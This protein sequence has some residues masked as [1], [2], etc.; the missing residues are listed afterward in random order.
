MVRKVYPDSNPDNPTTGEATSDGR[1]EESPMPREDGYDF[2][3]CVEEM[4][5]QNG[6][7]IVEFCLPPMYGHHHHYPYPPY[8]PYG[9]GGGHCPPPP[10]PEPIK[11][12]GRIKLN[13]DCA[14]PQYDDQFHLFPPNTQ[15]E[16]VQA[17]TNNVITANPGSKFGS[18]LDLGHVGWLLHYKVPV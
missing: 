18:L 16:D 5:E 15:R 13:M 10:C 12:R 2:D 11:V 8:P 17:Q 7:G 14:C 4:D 1:C 6:Y 9:Y 3:C